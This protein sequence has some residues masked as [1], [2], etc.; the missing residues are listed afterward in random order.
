MDL[1][2]TEIRGF[3]K[4]DGLSPKWN[5]MMNPSINILGGVPKIYVSSFIPQTDGMAAARAKPL[6]TE[7]TDN[8][9][10][11]QTAFRV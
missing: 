7:W 9:P 5:M 10:G 4:F 1:Y 6:E 2:E 11:C 8:E 3:S